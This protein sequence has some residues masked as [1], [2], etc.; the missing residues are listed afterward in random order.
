MASSLEAALSILKSALK[1]TR[2][3]HR[4]SPSDCLSCGICCDLFS[5]T[6]VP[7]ETDLER[8]RS[9][10]RG[11][12]LSWGKAQADSERE[13]CPFLKREGMTSGICA[14]NQTKPA[15]CRA[16]P[17]GAHRHICVMGV[18]FLQNGEEE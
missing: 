3:E 2:R 5:H 15:M 4:I 16:Y 11:D 8:W 18:R 7:D 12:I 6:V 17:T 14:I 9:E 10:G 1:I 13:P